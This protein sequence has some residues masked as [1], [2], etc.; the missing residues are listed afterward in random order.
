MTGVDATVSGPVSVAWGDWALGDLPGVLARVADLLGPTAGV[1]R[2]VVEFPVVWAVP[3][4]EVHTATAGQVEDMWQRIYRCG[5]R[6]ELLERPGD[7]GWVA[8]VGGI[9]LVVRLANDDEEE[10]G[11]S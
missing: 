7:G 4:V 9:E 6:V 10:E 3:T 11:S 2:V 5:E 1:L 8:Q